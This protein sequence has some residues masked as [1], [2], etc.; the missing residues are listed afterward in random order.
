MNVAPEKQYTDLYREA[1]GLLAAHSP[2]VMDAVRDEAFATFCAKGFPT[3]KDEAYKYTRLGPA[4]APDYGLNLARRPLAADPYAAFRCDVPNL[5]TSLFF[6]V[7]DT[8][9]AS[10]EHLAALTPGVVLTSL[11][12]AAVRFPDIVG[13]H[14]GRLAAQGDALTAFNTAFAED[15]VFLYVPD[16]VVMDKPLQLINVMSA[17]ADMM[18]V[19]R[20]LVVI[21]DR[22]SAKLLVCDH[23]DGDKRYLSTQV[24]E[25]FV[26]RDAVF[27][28][29][30]L[31]ET[32]PANTRVANTYIR[33]AAGSNVLANGVTLTCGTTRNHLSVDLAGEGAETMLGGIATLDARQHLDNN[34]L[35]THR[36]PRC[37]S[38]ELFKYVV[39]DEAVG[40][41]AGKV[42]VEPGAQKSVS[43]QTNKNICLTR[44][45][46]MY[47][48]PQLEIYADDVQC[49]HGATVGQLDEAAVFYMRQRGL[50]HKE[51][52]TLLIN[53]FVNEVIDHLR[54]DAL[55]E[56]LHLL[57]EKRFRGEL[58][59]CRTCRKCK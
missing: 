38:R 37:T 7:N 24:A 46:R 17:G 3:P 10:P 39:D 13:R 2:A 32:T 51:A 23:A 20:L 16:G 28:Y 14:Y 55:K 49:S 48:Q 15:G 43:Q 36:V 6:V 42:R 56:R 18:A 21:G 58:G 40:A 41:F 47:A 5:S 12:D 9:C 25:I 52:V 34:T 26:G 59:A 50:S 19:R 11:A 57:V 29:Y 35:I 44:T 30:E 8:L 33:Q 53:A 22:A 27:D 4:F 31:E 1:R 54:M 45:A